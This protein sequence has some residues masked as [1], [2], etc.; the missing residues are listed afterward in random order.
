ML[1][2]SASSRPNG[3]EYEV[4]DMVYGL[5]FRD[6]LDLDGRDAPAPSLEEA[7]A[8]TAR[9]EGRRVERRLPAGEPAS[10][11]ARCV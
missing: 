6:W 9:S 2:N 1:W 3:I 10:G 4:M 8:E 11:G 5:P 7:E